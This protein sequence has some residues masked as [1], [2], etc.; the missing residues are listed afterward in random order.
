MGTE[1][2][3]GWEPFVQ[4]DQSIVGDQMSGYHMRLG[5][6]VSQPPFHLEKGY[7]IY[8]WYLVSSDSTAGL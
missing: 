4:R 1:L 5:P 3:G 6:N 2:V 8:G 7:V